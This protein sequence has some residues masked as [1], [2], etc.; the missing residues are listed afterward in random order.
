MLGR[1]RPLSADLARAEFR[2]S[3]YDLNADGSFGRE[4]GGYDNGTTIGVKEPRGAALAPLT[5]PMYGRWPLER[6]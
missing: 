6:S 2:L 5:V 3:F 4:V 1:V